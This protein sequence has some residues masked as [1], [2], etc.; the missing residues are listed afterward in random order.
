MS[1]ERLKFF[2][3]DP[4]HGKDFTNRAVEAKRNYLRIFSQGAK[5][6]R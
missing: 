5:D 6:L 1:M 2:V 4:S 3:T